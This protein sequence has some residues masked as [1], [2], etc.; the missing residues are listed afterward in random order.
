[1]PKE[2]HPIQ[3]S[4]KSGGIADHNRSLT[5]ILINPALHNHQINSVSP[6][7]SWG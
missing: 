6:M 1:M 4:G 7:L 2:I 3:L 5:W